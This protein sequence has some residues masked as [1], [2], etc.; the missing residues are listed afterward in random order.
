MGGMNVCRMGTRTGPS[1]PEELDTNNSVSKLVLSN[2]SSYNLHSFAWELVYLGK[3]LLSKMA[4][5]EQ[6]MVFSCV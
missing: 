4:Y 6:K 2:N 5:V 1:F 3:G